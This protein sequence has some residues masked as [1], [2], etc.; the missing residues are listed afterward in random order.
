VL[1]RPVR[2]RPGVRE[3]VEGVAAWN[4]LS[5]EV[6][7]PGFCTG[8]PGSA[9]RNGFAASSR[10]GVGRGPAAASFTLR[11]LA[12]RDASGIT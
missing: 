2:G 9:A 11:V 10:T 8:V 5:V 4:R 6:G 1:W 3:G 7:E 12:C